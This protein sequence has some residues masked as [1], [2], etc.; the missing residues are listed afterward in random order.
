MVWDLSVIVMNL[1][2]FPVVA[3]AV[4]E[5]GA[6][7]KLLCVFYRNQILMTMSLIRLMKKMDQQMKQLFRLIGT[8]EYAQT[9]IHIY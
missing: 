3:C 6:L 4:E 1:E 2:S 8:Y 5:R 9:H 7:F